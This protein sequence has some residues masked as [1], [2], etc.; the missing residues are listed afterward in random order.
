MLI[1]S[2]VTEQKVE[3]FMIMPTTTTPTAGKCDYNNS[4]EL[5]SVYH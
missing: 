3:K 1:Y 2:K 4:V 5:K